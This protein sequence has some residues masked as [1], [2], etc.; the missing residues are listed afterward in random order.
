MRFRGGASFSAKPV[1]AYRSRAV[2]PQKGQAHANHQAIPGS[3][4]VWRQAQAPQSPD[5]IL[6][7][8]QYGST[9]NVRNM[10]YMQFGCK[11]ETK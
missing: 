7:H 11:S 8:L 6:N 5:K 2:S 10:R 3:R 4:L 1:W 9:A